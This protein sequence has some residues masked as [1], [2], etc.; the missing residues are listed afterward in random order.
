MREQDTDDWKRFLL[1]TK[2]IKASG[3][4]TQQQYLKA[5]QHLHCSLM[6]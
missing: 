6:V 5:S 3:K 4:W 1:D 2:L